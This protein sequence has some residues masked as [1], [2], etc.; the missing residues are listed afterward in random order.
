[1]GKAFRRNFNSQDRLEYAFLRIKIASEGLTN[2]NR[3]LK[4]YKVEV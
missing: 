3:G 1:V 4:M 2:S